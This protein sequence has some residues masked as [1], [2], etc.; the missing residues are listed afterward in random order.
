MDRCVFWST[1]HCTGLQ[2][3]EHVPVIICCFLC[4]LFKL[5]SY[6]RCTSFPFLEVASWLERIVVWLFNVFRTFDLSVNL[7]EKIYVYYDDSSTACLYC[8]VVLLNCSTTPNHISILS[9]LQTHGHVYLFLH[10]RLQRQ[11]LN[12]SPSS[13]YNLL[14]SKRTS[15]KAFALR[16]FERM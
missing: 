7:F 6:T 14:I 1:Y 16:S 3:V 10:S 2:V 5:N 12:S 15:L 4:H 13:I 9:I 11:S 8:H